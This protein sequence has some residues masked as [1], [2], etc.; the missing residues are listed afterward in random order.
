MIF[1][2]FVTNPYDFQYIRCLQCVHHI[3]CIGG[4]QCIQ[5][6]QSIQCF[7]QTEMKPNPVNVPKKT[8][9]RRQ[10]WIQTLSTYQK[11]QTITKTNAPNCVNVPKKPKIPK[12]SDTCR[13]A[14]H[15]PH[16]RAACVWKL[17]YFCF[18]W[19]VDTVWSSG[20]GDC[21]VFLVRWQGLDPFLS[22]LRWFFWYVDRVWLRFCFR[23]AV[24]PPHGRAACVWKLWYFWF[25]LV[26]W[27]SWAHLFWCL[28]GF[29]W[30]VDRVWLH[31]RSFKALYTLSVLYTLYSS[32]AL[33]MLYT[34]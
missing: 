22:P 24:P 31:F 19:Y 17:W 7:K 16:G 23:H 13:H 8:P 33:K 32:Y 2:G 9:W 27:H 34:L 20:F 30:Y 26:R 12:F 15:P 6:W 18:F 28:V 4:V 11:N 10:K 3:Q 21:L 5:H 14:V 1:K 25:L 29:C